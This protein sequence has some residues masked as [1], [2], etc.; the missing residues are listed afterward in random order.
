MNSEF[1]LILKK[2]QIQNDLMNE[3]LALL[4]N[5]EELKTNYEIKS[6]DFVSLQKYMND[7]S[8]DRLEETQQLEVELEGIKSQ[9]NLETKSRLTA[10]SAFNNEKLERKREQTESAKK[11][12]E[13]ENRIQ[14]AKNQIQLLEQE[15]V[16]NESSIA[17]KSDQIIK[18]ERLLNDEQQQVQLKSEELA[19]LVQQMSE[20]AT[21]HSLEVTKLEKL[22]KDAQS[23]LEV[24]ARDWNESRLTMLN[25]SEAL[26]TNTK[27]L[28][29]QI[30]SKSAELKQVQL[31]L[32]DTQNRLRISVTKSGELATKLDQKT[33][34]L[35]KVKQ[36]LDTLTSELDQG[37]VKANQL[38][39]ELSKAH[40]ALDESKNKYVKE[41][42]TFRIQLQQATNELELRTSEVGRCRAEL[43]EHRQQLAN[44][45]NTASQ[46]TAQCDQ[47]KATN[48]QLHK[49][50]DETIQQLNNQLEEN[51]ALNGKLTESLGQRQSLQ[52]DY[53]R[54]EAEAKSFVEAVNAEK[55]QLEATVTQQKTELVNLERN[56][57]SSYNALNRKVSETEAALTA[58]T[59]EVNSL[60]REHQHL[61]NTLE[62]Q[63]TNAVK[64]FDYEKEQQA[65][66]QK[67]LREDIQH[68]QMELNSLKARVK[69]MEENEAD[70]TKSMQELNDA[71]QQ[72]KKNAETEKMGHVKAQDMNTK[73]VAELAEK[74]DL[75]A[76]YD[77]QFTGIKEYAN[78]LEK[79][80]QAKK[81]SFTEAETMNKEL[82]ARVAKLEADVRSLKEENTCY[83]EKIKT[84][85]FENSQIKAQKESMAKRL[86][87]ACPD[88]ID[89]S[90]QTNKL[91]RDTSK[92]SL[93]NLLSLKINQKRV[94]K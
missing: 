48:Q 57:T 26:R 2:S 83:L 77:A 62:Q 13:L 21:S 35:K 75:I 15:K 23:E 17:A 86:N 94:F 91:A 27:E 65:N 74:T 31:E 55:R 53:N 16:V 89:F 34:D 69:Q 14:A 82:L 41:S 49:Q 70:C 59:N 44:E 66:V 51:Q 92:Y 78:K 71:I 61:S 5:F 28:T 22:L 29:D 60:Q 58:K 9:L 40:M 93:L 52:A 20:A 56:Y 63:Y 64:H 33:D 54:L 12:E 36:E 81:A 3:K 87:F 11:L 68:K 24:G 72:L 50:L 32:D 7:M 38:G 30:L 4:K 80:Y 45:T 8:R 42:E 6:N 79:H 1:I 10:E 76:N 85:N 19:K 18:L 73:L 67:R 88:S 46:L 25:E 47:L 39:M 84:V 90:Y 37:R 43:D